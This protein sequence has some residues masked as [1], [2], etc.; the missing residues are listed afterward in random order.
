MYGGDKFV[1]PPHK[2]LKN[3]IWLVF[4]L[5]MFPN[6][7]AIFPAVSMYDRYQNWS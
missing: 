2:R 4:K 7:K 6:L 5:G 3:L 1:P